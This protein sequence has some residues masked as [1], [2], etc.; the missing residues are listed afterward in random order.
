M[1]DKINTYLPTQFAE[2]HPHILARFA[3][4]SA[5]RAITMFSCP[6]GGQLHLTKLPPHMP[7]NLT[8]IKQA[9]EYIQ[10]YNRRLFNLCGH[11]LV[12]HRLF[13][14]ALMNYE[15]S[16]T[17]TNKGDKDMSGAWSDVWVWCHEI[18]LARATSVIPTD[19][20]KPTKSKSR[21]KVSNDTH[22]GR[23]SSSGN[24]PSQPRSSGPLT[25]VGTV[26]TMTGL[27]R[28][29]IHYRANRDHTKHD[30]SKTRGMDLSEK[31]QQSFDHS[32]SES[33]VLDLTMV[34]RQ[35]AS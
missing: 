24:Q 3:R 27:N 6:K 10:D 8:D 20:T 28:R 11:F 34:K 9:K 12:E 19:V 2:I 15:L 7:I 13:E 22:P 16:S 32:W 30:P 1:A 25:K 14:D 29:T 33:G 18:A 5:E 4:I 21:A 23:P 35:H 26:G 31:K 17:A